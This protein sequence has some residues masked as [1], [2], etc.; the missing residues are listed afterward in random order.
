MPD[1][2]PADVLAL[3]RLT[4]EYGLSVDV[5]DGP[6]FAKVFTPDGVLA[7]YE[8][9]ED[10]PSITYNGEEELAAVPE[11]VAPWP[12]TFHLMANQTYDFDGDQAE[13][14][15]YGLSLHFKVD[16]GAGE[17]TYMVMRYRDR[18]VRTDGSWKIARRD[19]LRQWTEYHVA[20]RARLA[21]SQNR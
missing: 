5:R 15:V 20:E 9:D 13:G 19:V 18:Y 17:D 12:S 10:E 7:V 3:R 1:P 16:G 6:R 4:D 14:L 2:D 8:P 21:D 11:L